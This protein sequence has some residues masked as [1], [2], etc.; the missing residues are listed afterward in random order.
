MIDVM[1]AKE[2][3]LSHFSALEKHGGA[4]GLDRLRQ[5]GIEHFAETGLP[6]TQDEDWRFT[7]LTSLA[8]TP[9]E[10]AETGQVP[11]PSFEE[12][13]AILP[14]TGQSQQLVLVNGRYSSS[15]SRLL[16]TLPGVVLGSLQAA[17]KN[18]RRLIEPKLGEFAA[19]DGAPFTALNTAFLNDGLFIY[20]PRGTVL[21]K[22]LHLVYVAT[23]GAAPT[24]M[25][26]RTLIVCEDNTQA[27]IVQS[28]VGHGEGVTFTNAVTEIVLG[29]NAQIDHVKVQRE[30]P[31][32]FHFETL[33]LNQ[34]RGS[35]FRSQSLTLLGRLVRNE[36]GTTLD[37]EGCECTLNGLYVGNT[38][39]HLDNRTTIDHAKPRC[40]SH[41]LYKGILDG[42]AKG[43][44]NGKILVRQDA[45]KTDAK[46]TN[47][48]L[49][50]SDDAVIH[51]KPQLEIFADDVKCTH[52]ATVGQV[53]G[54]A[55]FYLRCRGIGLEEAR[56]MLTFAFANDVLR[57][58]RVE[59]LRRELE[60]FFLGAEHALA[61][62]P[63][64]EAL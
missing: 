29:P 45:Q 62:E 43:V 47:K 4:D 26:P 6:T 28:Y 53:A 42:N 22:P 23:A 25:H 7:P 20:L 49:L 30:T 34:D 44:F 11:E 48:T 9:F 12:L 21:E 2:L 51:T 36:I 50:L 33:Q 18:H 64:S 3:F 39:Q 14:Q 61:M 17:W 54:E 8:A 37:G 38:G 57:Q 41:E 60:E 63:D 32:A 40:A 59:P 35:N 1:D 27:T 55:L 19:I 52:G 15:L 46:Q 24:V 31:Q 13:Q 5:A 16:P 58:I 56:A 10:L